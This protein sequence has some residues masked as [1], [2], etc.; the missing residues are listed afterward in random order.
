MFAALKIFNML[1][2][3]YGIEVDAVMSDNGAEFCSGPKKTILLNV[4]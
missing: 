2:K 1:K 3:Q 4:Y